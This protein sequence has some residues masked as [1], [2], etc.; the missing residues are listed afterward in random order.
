MRVMKRE[1]MQ[2][3]KVSFGSALGPSLTRVGTEVSGRTQQEKTDCHY[4]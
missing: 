3:W 4:G 1:R 2:D